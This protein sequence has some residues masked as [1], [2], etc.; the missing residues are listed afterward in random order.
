MPA[1]DHRLPKSHVVED[2]SPTEDAAST[3]SWPTMA[4]HSDL[5]EEEIRVAFQYLFGGTHE[6][7]RNWIE[8]GFKMEKSR[9]KE[10]INDFV[11]HGLYSHI[12][13]K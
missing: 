12:Y 9:L 10:L 5:S 3:P 11:K 4:P 1:A 8:S 2:T 6:I 13:T 7:L